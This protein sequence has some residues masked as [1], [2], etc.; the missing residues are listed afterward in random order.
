MLY[1]DAIEATFQRVL[2]VDAAHRREHDTIAER[3]H[4]MNEARRASNTRT[5]A[6]QGLDLRST[7]FPDL[8]YYGAQHGTM[9]SQLS[10]TIGRLLALTENDL[11]VVKTAGIYHDIGREKTYEHADAQH[12]VRSAEIAHRVL[13]G[14]K[15]GHGDREFVAKVCRLIHMHSLD[16]AK[17]ADLMM[18]TLHDADALDSCR[19]L[20]GTTVGMLL[21]QRRKAQCCTPFGRNKEVWAKMMAHHGW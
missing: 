6:V 5:S 13:T 10:D 12:N 16:G 1:N 8:P 20:P 19:I 4:A 9:V 11:E 17:P 15:D 14:R 3:D 7:P 2:T 21:I 18:Q